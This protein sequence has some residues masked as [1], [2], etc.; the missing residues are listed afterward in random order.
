[1]VVA[2]S[3]PS[4]TSQSVLFYTDNR[5]MVDPSENPMFSRA[6]NSTPRSRLQARRLS[7]STPRSSASPRASW[8]GA[9]PRAGFAAAVADRMTAQEAADYAKSMEDDATFQIYMRTVKKKGFFDDVQP[10]T[11]EYERR[12]SKV[13][14]TFRKKMQAMTPSSKDKEGHGFAKTPFKEEEEPVTAPAPAPVAAPIEKKPVPAPVPAVAVAP[15]PTPVPAPVPTAV[16]NEAEPEKKNHEYEAGLEAPAVEIDVSGVYKQKEADSLKAKGNE[17]MKG[18]KYTKAVELYTKAVE[19]NPNGNGTHVYLSNRATAFCRL[20][21]NEEAIGDL[22]AALKLNPGHGKHLARLGYAQ[23]QLGREEEALQ[24]FRQ[25]AEAEDSPSVQ[26]Y[27]QDL[28]KRLGMKKSVGGV[29][30]T[31]AARLKRVNSFLAPQEEGQTPGTPGEVS[32]AEV[33]QLIEKE[34]SQ[35]APATA[36]ATAPVVVPMPIVVPK[37]KPAEPKTEAPVAVP[38]PMILPKEEPI[39][40]QIQPPSPPKAAEVIAVAQSPKGSAQPTQEDIEAIEARLRAEAA[41]RVKAETERIRKE[42]QDEMRR[43]MRQQ[44]E[45]EMAAE[46]RKL[47]EAQAAAA[48]AAAAKVT[49]P[50]STSKSDDVDSMEAAFER[51]L[52]RFMTPDKMEKMMVN[53]LSNTPRSS[54][55]GFDFG[56]ISAPSSPKLGSSAQKRPS[57][58]K[59]PTP[60]V[61][62]EERVVAQLAPKSPPRRKIFKNQFN[63]P[64]IDTKGRPAL[65]DE[66]ITTTPELTPPPGEEQQESEPLPYYRR[67]LRPS[68]RAKDMMRDFDEGFN[69]SPPKERDVG[70]RGNSPKRSPIH[71]SPI[72]SRTP[73]RTSHRRTG[74][75]GSVNDLIGVFNRS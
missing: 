49:E 45:A 50:K 3:L 8:G 20:G 10:G 55:G 6:S 31:P 38:A 71:S 7:G 34:K 53:I 23:M 39:A 42:M 54:N 4:N 13:I 35:A 11:P 73:S 69:C 36:P 9:S 37:Q 68:P 21:R 58:V 28:E 27:I 41:E 40:Q 43:E 75:D 29:E 62:K 25:A 56:S 70:G 63:V 46:R 5:R 15:V 14:T 22:E 17:A 18:K 52:Q 64:E 61:T 32:V 33:E 2:H 51:A 74:T 60:R 59:P 67:M 12:Y 48:A 44:M 65:D 24:T 19:L 26:R 47:E 72:I 1:V 57:A 66:D 16:I 30:V